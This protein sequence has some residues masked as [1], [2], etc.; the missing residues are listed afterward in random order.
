MY[1]QL[2][3]TS[4][5][6]EASRTRIAHLPSRLSARDCVKSGG[7]CCTMRTGTSRFPGRAG[8]TFPSAAGPPVETPINTSSGLTAAEG[9]AMRCVCSGCAFGGTE[10]AGGVRSGC[11]TRNLDFLL[12]CSDTAFRRGTSSAF[13]AARLCAAP[14]VSGLVF[15]PTPIK[16]PL[17]KFTIFS[18]CRRKTSKKPLVYYI[19]RK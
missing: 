1:I 9:R 6:S 18:K 3:S 17:K 10:S 14:C 2:G 4:V 15:S 13:K 16:V 11:G 7:M 5:A 8:S 12:K 19:E